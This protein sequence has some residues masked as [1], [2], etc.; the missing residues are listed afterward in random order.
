M[1][2]TPSGAIRSNASSVDPPVL[3]T[4]STSSTR[5]P[6]SQPGALD[7]LLAAALLLLLAHR[8]PGLAGDHRDAVRQRVG[9]HGEPADGVELDAVGGGEV[10]D[11]AADDRQPL[12]GVDGVLA[13]D[14][15]VAELTAGQLERL[16]AAFV[17]AGADQVERGL[18]GLGALGHSAIVCRLRPFRARRVN[19]TVAER[20]SSI[21][22]DRR[23]VPDPGVGHPARGGRP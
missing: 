19:S 18:P 4:S 8:E 23:R 14:V 20:N 2:T 17:A 21:G 22:V 12:A 5:V 9:A 11:G 1:T 10:G 6:G 16:L 13:V 7:P 3:M 15:V